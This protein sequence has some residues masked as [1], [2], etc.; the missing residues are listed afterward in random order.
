MTAA[1]EL[2]PEYAVDELLELIRNTEASVTAMMQQGKSSQYDVVWGRIKPGDRPKSLRKMTVQQVLD[3]QDSI[4]AR[5]GSEA[6][7]AYQFMEDTLRGIPVDRKKLFDEH[8]Q[9]ICAIALLE[10]RGLKDYLAGHM[11]QAKFMTAIAREWA[12]FPVPNDMTVVRGGKEYHLKRGDSY[13]SGDT[14]GNKALVD[15]SL[16]QKVLNIMRG[17]T[18]PPEPEPTAEEK[19]AILW[20]DYQKRTA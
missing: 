5:Y 1:T 16:V 15:A 12:S 19:L 7:G 6:A 14:V 17:P 8:M 18:Q 3:W 20:A 9:D 11:P 4:D 10:I 2:Y 13:Y